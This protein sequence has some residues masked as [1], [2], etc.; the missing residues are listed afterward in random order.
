M[1]AESAYLHGL[2]EGALECTGPY[3]PYVAF[4]RGGVF[5]RK[6]VDLKEADVHPGLG[7]LDWPHRPI[8]VFSAHFVLTGAHPGSTSRLVTHR[9]IAP[10]QARLT[11]SFFSDELPEKKVYLIDMSILS[12]LLSHVTHSPP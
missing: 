5:H 2:G 7:F 1:L 4:P 8:L 12:I 10:G 9:Q 11:W 6:L 3:G